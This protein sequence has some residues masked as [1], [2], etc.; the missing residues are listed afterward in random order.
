MTPEGRLQ[1]EIRDIVD[2]LRILIHIAKQ[3]EEVIAKF[4]TGAQ[5]ILGTADGRA[6]TFKSSNVHHI[7][8]NG[9]KASIFIGQ[10]QD[11]K[12]TVEKTGDQE[13]I[14][15]IRKQQQKSIDRRSMI[16]SAKVTELIAELDGLKT[17][18]ESTA[19]SVRS[20]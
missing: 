14:E 9:G 19:Q 6:R 11:E 2:E 5:D 12:K 16:L 7:T 18:A 10:Q 3:Q 8:I 20:R 15:K 17:S 1:Q 13:A 4:I